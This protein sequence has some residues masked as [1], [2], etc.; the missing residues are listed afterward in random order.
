MSFKD[1]AAQVRTIDPLAWIYG[2]WGFLMLVTAMVL[3]V[4]GDRVA[5]LMVGV[6]AGGLFWL[7]R[8]I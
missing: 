2:V 7:A 3:Q 4:Q 5:A 6:A 8:H 1:I